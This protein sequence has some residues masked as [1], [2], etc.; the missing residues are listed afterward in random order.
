MKKG[1]FRAVPFLR[2]VPVCALEEKLPHL[3]KW[4]HSKNLRNKHASGLRVR[5][6][7]V[8]LPLICF[9]RRAILVLAG[10]E[11]AMQPN[12]RFLL[13]DRV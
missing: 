1:P 4:R 12:R 11:G 9:F 7:I 3:Q 5:S 8:K 10:P 6:A 2:H 13:E